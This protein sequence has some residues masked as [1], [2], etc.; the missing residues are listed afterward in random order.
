MRKVMLQPEEPKHSFF[1][2]FNFISKSLALPL[3]VGVVSDEES[4]DV[5]VEASVDVKLVSLDGLSVTVVAVV[6]VT[7]LVLA[8]VVALRRL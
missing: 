6:I 7:V 8:V 3:N 1:R 2:I 5:S 4:D